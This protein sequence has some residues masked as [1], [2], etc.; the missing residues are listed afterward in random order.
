VKNKRGNK[1]TVDAFLRV[2]KWLAGHTSRSIRISHEGYWVA[3]DDA[4]I[5]WLEAA[6][7]S[8]VSLAKNLDLEKKRKGWN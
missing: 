5:P 6:G 4:A 2:G 7:K 8:I 3:G 1:H